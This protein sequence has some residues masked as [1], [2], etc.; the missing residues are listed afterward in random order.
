MAHIL[1]SM[2]GLITP[3]RSVPSSPSLSPAIVS[4]TNAT[5]HHLHSN[6]S[7]AVDIEELTKLLYQVVSKRP[8]H[9][10]AS[11]S[12]TLSSNSSNS[13]EKV[14]SRSNSQLPLQFVFKKPLYNQVYHKTH[15][16]HSQMNQQPCQD[17]FLGW[18]DLRRFFV[19]EDDKD[20]KDE[21]KSERFANQFRQNI[22]SRYGKWGRYLGKGAGGSVRL[23]QRAKDQKTFAVKQF[24]KRFN[25]E[26]EKD[27]VKKVTAE[28]CIGSTL[29]HPNIIETLDIIQQDCQFY[30]IME[31]APNE[32]FSLV[33]SGM[34]SRQEI[35]CCWRQLLQGVDYLH[36]MGIAHR[37]L[38]LDNVVLD[39]M[40]MLK[41]IDFGCSTV[42]KYPFENAITM[43]KGIYGSDPYIAPEQYVQSTYDPRLSDVWSCGIIFVC[44]TIRRFPW[45]IPRNTDPA[46]RAFATNHN[47]QKFRLLKLLPRESRSVMTSILELDPSHRYSISKILQDEWVKSIDVCSVQEPGAHHVHHVSTC[48]TVHRGNLVAV[49]PEPPG[50]V[51]EKEKRKRQPIKTSIGVKET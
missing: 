17:L 10:P 44:M 35:A 6:D 29:H 4:A 16:H 39:H 47:Q 27:Y 12:S 20:D 9:P 2:N 5:T 31:Y 30:E 34:M 23:I 18:S 50:V 1:H 40:G 41:I 14:I 49:T 28:F 8:L 45:R 32:L 15:F 46:F 22:E 21:S 24:R 43:T 11:P 19:T 51:A 13:S 48:P 36:S 7:S 37:D 25:H 33:M 3:E 42:Y 26:S 38:K